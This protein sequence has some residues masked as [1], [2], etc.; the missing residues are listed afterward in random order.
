MSLTRLVLQ[1][2]GVAAIALSFTA[3][4]ASDDASVKERIEPVGSL[5]MAGE[6]CAA[7]VVASADTG[8]RSGQAVY[9]KSCVACHNTGAA[10]APKLGDAAA[11]A[12]RIA[13]GMD[14]VYENAWNGLNAMPA[15]GLCMDCTREEM[16][17]AV[18]YLVENS[19]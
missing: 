7:S 11:W 1:I 14:T 16:D 15:K 12:P 8:P 6:D 10:N 13:K 2:A 4:A 9:E 17:N 5:C 19:Q 3:F 18:D